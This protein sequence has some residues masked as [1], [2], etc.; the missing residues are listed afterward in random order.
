MSQ[1]NEEKLHDSADE[2]ESRLN[3]SG[4]VVLNY[5]DAERL[6]LLMRESANELFMVKR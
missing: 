5:H 3:E 4:R 2:I 6:V 1:T